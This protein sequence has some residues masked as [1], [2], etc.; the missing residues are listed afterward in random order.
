MRAILRPFLQLGIGLWRI[1]DDF[2]R[3]DLHHLTVAPHHDRHSKLLVF[4]AGISVRTIQGSVD[5]AA[6]ATHFFDINVRL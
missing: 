5:L 4:E 6:I 1:N 3:R 2:F